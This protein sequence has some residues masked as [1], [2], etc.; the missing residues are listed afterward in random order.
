MVAERES[1]SDHILTAPAGCC[2]CAPQKWCSERRAQPQGGPGG[3]KPL[4]RRYLGVHVGQAVPAEA[5]EQAAA[6]ELL[7]DDGDELRVP[8]RQRGRVG[9]AGP[10]ARGRAA[11]VP[12]TPSASRTA[13]SPPRG[14]PTGAA[15][16][17]HGARPEPGA[18][19]RL[20]PST[21]ARRVLRNK[22]RCIAGRRVLRRGRP[23]GPAGAAWLGGTTAPRVH[24]ERT[25]RDGARG[26][27]RRFRDASRE[28]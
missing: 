27:K 17:G 28:S 23:C 15:A 20:R 5:I 19:Q 10:G 13:A 2:D 16:L 14:G 24:R 25:P 18:R 21:A 3:Q 26:G 11:R 1:R 7:H 9:G 4:R 22:A 12:R 6:L 8:G